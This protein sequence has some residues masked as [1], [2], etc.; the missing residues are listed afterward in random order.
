MKA[1]A[2]PN[3]RPLRYNSITFR[4][5]CPSQKPQASPPVSHGAHIQ[6]LSR[7][8]YIEYADNL[9]FVR[10]FLPCFYHSQEDMLTRK[11][12]SDIIFYASLTSLGGILSKEIEI[13]LSS[14]SMDF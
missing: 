3:L 1:Q 12:A 11:R 9:V 7:Y 13:I 2:I 6:E 10:T 14:L 4:A 5:W 8:I